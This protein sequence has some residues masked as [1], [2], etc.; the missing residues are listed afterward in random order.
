[1]MIIPKVKVR[2]L[3]KLAVIGIKCF[4]KKIANLNLYIK[5][6]VKTKT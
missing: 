3:P 4:G 5:A 6:S 1:M 2:V